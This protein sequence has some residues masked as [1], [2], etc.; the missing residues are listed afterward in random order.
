MKNQRTTK[1]LGYNRSKNK[2]F[3]YKQLEERGIFEKICSRANSSRELKDNNF[4]H[5]GPPMVP[6]REFNLQ[7]SSNDGLQANCRNCE[8]KFRR[9]RIN[10]NSEKF[11]GLSKD[12]IVR[13]YMDGYGQYKTCG[14]CNKS[15][16]PLDFP[17][18][19]TMETGLHNQCNSCMISVESVGERWIR[20]SP[21]GH[22]VFNRSRY[23]DCSNLNCKSEFPKKLHKDHRWPI[24]KGGT[25]NLENI[26]ALCENCNFSK[27]NSVDE[28]KCLSEVKNEMICR[29]YWVVLEDARNLS[30]SIREF[31]I[32]ISEAVQLFLDEKCMYGES[33]LRDFFES[34]KSINNR[35]HSV[36]RAIK[37]YKEFCIQRS[38]RKDD[39]T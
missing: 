15:L 39:T 8:K 20:F 33:Y 32:A 19:R 36:D 4:F 12:E 24:S 18:S 7:A 9:R 5:E 17:L 31:E 29:R 3:I 21:D 22:S 10:K 28:F 38:K 23:N 35:K 11:Y 34:E 26:Q 16:S 1:N 6:I 37:K 2:E 30:S 14:M 13:I 27:N 25:D